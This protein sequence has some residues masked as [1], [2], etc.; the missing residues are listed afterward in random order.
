[1]TFWIRIRTK[2]ADSPDV[3][4]LLL[5]SVEQISDSDDAEM[6]SERFVPA[7]SGHASCSKAVSATSQGLD[8]VK[9]PASVSGVLAGHASDSVACPSKTDCSDSESFSPPCGHES[10]PHMRRKLDHLLR[11]SVPAPVF[12]GTIFHLQRFA[13]FHRFRFN[14]L[15]RRFPESVFL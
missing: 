9:E 13:L 1:M 7:S 6:V 5:P 4:A 15:K 3:R 14:M 2:V 10:P 8:A 11:H 12:L